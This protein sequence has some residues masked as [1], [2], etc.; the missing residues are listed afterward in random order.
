MARPV[1][2]CDWVGSGPL[3]YGL[4]NP[5]IFALEGPEAAGRFGFT[6]SLAGVVG[7]YSEVWIASRVAVFTSLNGAAKWVELKTLFASSVRM[8]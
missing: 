7:A 3:T 5:L 6:F 1:A 4:F 2:I 8:A